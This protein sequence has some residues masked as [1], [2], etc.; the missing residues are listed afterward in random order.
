[1]INSTLLTKL[2][3]QSTV[4]TLGGIYNNCFYLILHNIFQEWVDKSLCFS[5]PDTAAVQNYLPIIMA[6][7]KI[8]NWQS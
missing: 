1:M 6:I 8:W 7:D 4:H 5:L 2:K 3:N